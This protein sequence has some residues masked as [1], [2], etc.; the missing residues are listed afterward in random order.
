MKTQEI[1]DAAGGL[2]DMSR[3]R[4]TVLTLLGAFWPGHEA[5]G[6]NQSFLGLARAL[7]GE[8]DF[9][10]L[11]R[12]RSADA[13][14][15]LASTGAWSR[16]D[17]ADFRYCELRPW[18][19]R[20]LREAICSTPH[21]ALIL[22]GFFDR[23]F[24]IPALILR[25]AGLTPRR[26]TIL[27]PRG[28]FSAGSA[29]LAK[30]HKQAYLALSRRLGLFDGVWMHATGEGE[31]EDIRR[32]CPFAAHVVVAP[33][34][35]GLDPGWR[36]P[37]IEPVEGR[38]LRLVFLSRIDRKK[39]LDYALDILRRVDAPIAFDIFGP[40]SDDAYW[41]ACR[42]II[43]ALPA[44]VA[45]AYRGTIPNAEVAATLARY[46]AFL[47]P[48]AGENFGH[49]IFDALA[50]GVP[51]ILSDRTPWL[52]LDAREAGWSLSLDRPQDFVDTIL[53]LAAMRADERLRLSLGARRAAEEA[54]SSGDAVRRNREMLL[55]AVASRDS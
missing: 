8:F 54:V 41:S 50:A 48:T 1:A 30:P 31:A 26:P 45:V 47:L 15:A 23:E 28:E 52:A 6:P 9:K 32:H 12:D 38:R 46:D 7:G 5:T 35:R 39:N 34:I 14:V 11:A 43:A 40:V 18:G 21:D 16:H 22:N 49:A 51:A 20:G 3:K 4:P 55:S 53:R 17:I 13:A 33:N 27:S 42:E 37:A 24:T 2:S 36:P 10:V 29:A 25:W 19:A 44:N